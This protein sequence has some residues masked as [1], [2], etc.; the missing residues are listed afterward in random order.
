MVQHM[1]NPLL[2]TWDTPFGLP[3][4]DR[5]EVGQFGPAFD[6]AFSEARAAVDAIAGAGEAPS[7]ANTIE[8]ME[9]SDRLLDQVAAVFFNL[10]GAHSSDAIEALQ[11]DLSPRLAA[12]HSETMLNGAL[13][14]RVAVL[15]AQKGSMGLSGEQERVLDLYHRMFVRAGAGLKGPDRKRLSAIMQRLASLG[16][17]FSQNVL[18]DEKA[19]FMELGAEDLEISAVLAGRRRE[20]GGRRAR[21]CR[22]R[23]HTLAQ[24]DRALL[25]D[26]PGPGIARKGFHRLDFAGG[27]WGRDGQSRYRRRNPCSAGRAGKAAGIS[28]FRG[29]QA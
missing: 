8:A 5:I 7:F 18:A 21:D 14:K 6:A 27:D 29:L 15:H 12:F 25:A 3:P 4:F 17:S 16:T 26:L 28:E 10:A 19:W 1:D 23:D 24:S 9:R 11:R 22:T 20:G 2:E 13:F